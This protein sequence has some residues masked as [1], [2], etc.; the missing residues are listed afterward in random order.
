MKNFPKV[1]FSCV[2]SGISAVLVVF[3]LNMATA[4]YAEPERYDFP[5][6]GPVKFVK[7]FTPE[8][9]E[10]LAEKMD[11]RRINEARRKSIAALLRKYNRRLTE[12]QAYDYAVLIMQTCEAFGQDP[13][14]IA[15]LI[16]IESSA[17]SD[18]VSRGGDYGLMQVRWRVHQKNIRSKYPHIAKAKDMLV[19]QNN[20]TVGIEIFSKYHATAK[21]D[22][23][24]TLLYYSAGNRRMADKVAAAL[25]QLE[26]SYVAHLRNI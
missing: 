3:V 19:P 5:K 7:P 11:V 9:E 6:D 26:K 17:R 8:P 4:A 10:V 18:A 12:E 16:V 23:R 22:L 13:F 14:V 2:Y 1:S 21:Q 24:R 25:S 15:S 20:L